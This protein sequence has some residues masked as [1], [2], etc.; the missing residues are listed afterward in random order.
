MAVSTG[1]SAR[2]TLVD[3]SYQLA[4]KAAYRLMCVYW[5]VRRPTTHG[6]LV[7]LWNEGEI[8]LVRNSYVRYHTLPGGYVAR[9]E[10]SR[11]AAVRELMEEVG[12]TARPEE[13]TPLYDEQRDWE[14]KRDRVEIFTLEREQ[15]PVV[16]IDHREVVQAS[17][18]SP[19]RA[20]ALDLF[21]PLRPMIAARR[22]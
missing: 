18:F 1:D 22:P 2:P 10:S 14:G 5:R 8:L 11:Q 19:E 20:L 4:Y 16:R 12:I 6:A 21:P 3:R 17:W 7:A 13:L 9:A 15:R